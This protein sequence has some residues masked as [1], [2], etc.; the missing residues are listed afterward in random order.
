[1][2]KRYPAIALVTFCK[3]PEPNENSHGSSPG[4]NRPRSS[5]ALSVP[6]QVILCGRGLL[7][8]RRAT[9]IEKPRHISRRKVVRLLIQSGRRRRIPFLPIRSRLVGVLLPGRHGRSPV[10][11]DP[12]PRLKGVR[13]VPGGGTTPGLPAGTGAR[14]LGLCLASGAKV[15][16]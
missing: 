12:Q 4:Q 6:S 15:Q 5:Q 3:L 7:G 2:Q 11:V 9:I 1:M 16:E 13:T 10:L 14:F 8:V